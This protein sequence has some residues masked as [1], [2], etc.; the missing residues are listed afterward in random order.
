M[1]ILFDDELAKEQGRSKG[2]QPH[3]EGQPKTVKW[4]PTPKYAKQKTGVVDVFYKSNRREK[5]ADSAR[6]RNTRRDKDGTI[7][8]G[9]RSRMKERLKV[10]GRPVK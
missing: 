1:G 5:R 3:Y 2:P 4:E 8:R 6:V 9:Y 10:F 7:Y